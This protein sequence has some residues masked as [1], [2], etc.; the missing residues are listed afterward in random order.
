MI[1]NKF[2]IDP[3][4]LEPQGLLYFGT[5]GG[6]L[7]SLFSVIE[8]REPP[9]AGGRHVGYRVYCKGASEILLSKCT[10]FVGAQGIPEPF[11]DEARDQMSRNVVHRMALQG[12]RTILIGYKVGAQCTVF[13]IQKDY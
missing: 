3:P 2:F 6:N 11:T 5:Y 7:C 8:L 12:L 13:Q 10:H 1:N 4:E 9:N